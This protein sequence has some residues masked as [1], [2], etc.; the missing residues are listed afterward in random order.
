MNINSFFESV[1]PTR[2]NSTAIDWVLIKRMPDC[3]CLEG[4]VMK[5]QRSE[6]TLMG[7]ALDATS[8]ERQY[9][10]VMVRFSPEASSRSRADDCSLFFCVERPVTSCATSSGVGEKTCLLW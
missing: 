2:I 1:A 8:A 6:R 9:P 3:D 10:T 4:G 5:Y 7:I